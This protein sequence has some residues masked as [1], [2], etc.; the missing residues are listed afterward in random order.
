MRIPKISNYNSIDDRET[1]VLPESDFNKPSY[2]MYDNKTR[3]KF[4]KTVETMVRS[5]FEY[6]K[7]ISYLKED[8]DMKYDMFFQDI[9]KDLGKKIGIEI[10]HIPFTLYDIVSIVLKRYES[11]DIP[12]DPLMIAR[13]VT[14]L[15]YQG[16]VGLVPLSTTV[17]QL[18]HR[19]DIFIPL[20]YVDK[21]FV[22]FY[23]AYKPYMAEYEP[24]LIRLVSMSKAFDMKNANQILRKH[25]IYLQ[26]YGYVSV[27]ERL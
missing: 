3:N 1:I 27:P 11:E 13:E 9:S 20:Q 23:Q 5:S 19:G 10:H 21:G 6:K 7:L 14:M 8:L 16:M 26:N 17:H 22:S 12:I 25:L 24:M 15:H 4:I 18:Y 2:I